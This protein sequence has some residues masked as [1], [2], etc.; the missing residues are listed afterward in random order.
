MSHGFAHLHS[1]LVTMRIV[2]LVSL[3][4]LT[5][6]R[7]SVLLALLAQGQQIRTSVINIGRGE[8]G[9][10]QSKLKVVASHGFALA[11]CSV[12]LAPLVLLRVIPCPSPVPLSGHS[13]FIRPARVNL[14]PSRTEFIARCKERRMS[15]FCRGSEEVARDFRQL[16]EERHPR[17]GWSFV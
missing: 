3:H 2:P 9:P 13:C 4:I 15:Q 6:K 11:S 5:R 7:L 17:R 10:V 8:L 1:L 14:L 16:S 12:L